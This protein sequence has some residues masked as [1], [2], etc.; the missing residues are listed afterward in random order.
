MKGGAYTNNLSSPIA[1]FAQID[2]DGSH[3]SPN[4]SNPLNNGRIQ[5]GGAA[6]GPG[7]SLLA[8]AAPILEEHTA[9]YTTAPSQ[10][11]GS[12]G[13]PVLLNQPLDGK[14]WSKAC[15]QTG[16]KNK[17]KKNKSKKNKSK[18]NK[19]NKNKS[20]SRKQM[21]GGLEEDVNAALKASGMNPEMMLSKMVNTRGYKSGMTQVM[22]EYTFRVLGEY[23]YYYLYVKK[24]AD[25]DSTYV[26]IK[27]LSD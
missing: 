14:M 5:G 11:V 26:L 22:G 20:G 24:S 17:S 2:R 18:K 25:D 13:A 4:H 1:G 6:V 27:T 10:W 23:R 21:G 16:G 15:A 8:S 19:S 12:T 9:R 3:C 7:G